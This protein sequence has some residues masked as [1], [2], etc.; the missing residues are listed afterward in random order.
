[1]QSLKMRK[2]VSFSWLYYFIIIIPPFYYLLKMKLIKTQK[3]ISLLIIY[4][5][6]DRQ[7]APYLKSRKLAIG[8]SPGKCAKTLLWIKPPLDLR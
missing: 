6:N 2:K 4:K 1:M 8:R 3:H 7:Q 5:N